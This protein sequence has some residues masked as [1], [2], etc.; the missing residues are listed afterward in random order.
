M[1]DAIV[2]FCSDPPPPR[3]AYPPPPPG[4]IKEMDYITWNTKEGILV[5]CPM[6]LPPLPLSSSHKHPSVSNLV[7][8]KAARVLEWLGI[9][10]SAST[11]AAGYALNYVVTGDANNK[12]TIVSTGFMRDEV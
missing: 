7:L 4:Y 6:P 2:G 1:W 8:Q 12:N 3:A 10:Y 11:N 9:D 5:P